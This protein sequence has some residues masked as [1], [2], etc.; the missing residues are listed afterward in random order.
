MVTSRAVRDGG[1]VMSCPVDESMMCMQGKAG[2]I[3]LFV[4]M[5]RYRCGE[6]WWV[7]HLAKLAIREENIVAM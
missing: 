4:N 6:P 7:I 2:D 1:W 5:M 3:E